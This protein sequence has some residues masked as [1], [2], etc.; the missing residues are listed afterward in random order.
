MIAEALL[1]AALLS[2]PQYHACPYE[3]S[4]RCVWDAKHMGNGSGTSFVSGTD[5]G[6]RTHV[7]HRIAHNVWVTDG[8][9]RATDFWIGKEV[10]MVD[11]LG[12]TKTVNSRT[13]MVVSDTTYFIWPWRGRVGS[14]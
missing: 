13:M 5:E 14:S 2:G 7:R 3:D 4:L 8:W 9:H 10:D 1:A 6:R 12:G 11:K